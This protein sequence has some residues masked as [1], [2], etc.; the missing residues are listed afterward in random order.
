MKKN[1]G[2]FFADYL[3]KSPE[4]FGAFASGCFLHQRRKQSHYVLYKSY[5]ETLF[6]LFY[7]Y[8][9]TFF[10]RLQKI[11]LYVC[12]GV[13]IVNHRAALEVEIQAPEIHIGRS[14]RCNGIVGNE[15]L[16][17]Y[18]PRSVFKYFYAC[19]NQFSVI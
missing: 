16:G 19:F 6:A 10:K 18:K 4:I 9:L 8:L 3:S 15:Y 12:N 13:F 2:Y 14:Y 7:A 1:D 17:M 11:V 5:R